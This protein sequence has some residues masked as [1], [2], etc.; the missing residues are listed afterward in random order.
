MS[1]IRLTWLV[2][3][4]PSRIGAYASKSD[5]SGTIALSVLSDMKQCVKATFVLAATAASPPR[6]ALREKVVAPRQT[7]A[8][9]SSWTCR[10][11]RHCAGMFATR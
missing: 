1:L 10:L 5:L 11:F 6:G 7:K 8:D 4:A 2:R 9:V 3:L